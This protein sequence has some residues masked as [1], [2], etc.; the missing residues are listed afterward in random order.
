MPG[1]RSVRVEAIPVEARENDI[2]LRIVG[3]VTADDV[4]AWCE[5]RLSA[6]KQ[7]SEL[8]ITPG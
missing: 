7:P 6:Y 1:V 8:A 5:S 4:K 3:S 2:A